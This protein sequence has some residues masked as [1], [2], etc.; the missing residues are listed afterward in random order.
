MSE[1]TGADNRAAYDAI[2]DRW[3]E[4]RTQ[5]ALAERRVL[6]SALASVPAGAEMLDLGCGTGRPVAEW[7]VAQGF[8]V[9]GV[10]Q[11]SAMLAHAK[12]L[13]PAQQWVLSPIEE[14]AT[15]REFAAVIAWDSLFHIPR[16]RIPAIFAKV[17]RWLQPQGVFACTL[18]GSAQPAFDDEM[19]G[20]RFAYD[21]PAP[22]DVPALLAD[23]GLSLREQVVLN[24][25]DGGRDKGRIA[26][27]ATL[28]PRDS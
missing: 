15:A 6:E 18:G 19:F 28:A 9:T 22:S 13:L 26:Y 11:S 17:S 2:A 8:N 7:L 16:Q 27:V 5:L 4:A 21:S 23:A 14:F 12:R 10:D 1:R 25:P 20:Q 24:H 3:L